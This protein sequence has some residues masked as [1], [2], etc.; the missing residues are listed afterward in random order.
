MAEDK[1]HKKELESALKQ[2]KTIQA[3]GA[4][5]WRLNVPVWRLAMEGMSIFLLGLFVGRGLYWL[6]EIFLG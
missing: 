6:Y 2:I 5:S 3:R 1:R 4:R